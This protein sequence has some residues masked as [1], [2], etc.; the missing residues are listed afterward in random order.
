MKIAEVRSDLNIKIN[1][2]TFDAMV[3]LLA[4]TV[5]PTDSS[6]NP[7][8]PRWSAVC[9][10]ITKDL[11]QD[12][13]DAIGAE[14]KSMDAKWEAAL[15]QS[16]TDSDLNRLLDFYRSSLGKR[17]LEFQKSLDPIIAS[18]GAAVIGSMST[19][20]PVFKGMDSV[21]PSPQTV[22]L[23]QRVFRLSFSNRLAASALQNS[24]AKQ[25]KD[26]IEQTALLKHGP[27]LDVIARHYSADL[28]SFDQFQQSAPVNLIVDAGQALVTAQG[29]SSEGNALQAV[30]MAEPTKHVSQWQAVYASH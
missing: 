3:P 23:R 7:E 22:A 6:W 4:R 21:S 25:A 2:S 11:H 17:Y 20:R 27:A 26:T 8:H 24:Q 18:A 15:D 10:L 29:R 19:A 5:A 28:P 1:V 13:A 16:L 14:Q 30:L 12:L 9:A